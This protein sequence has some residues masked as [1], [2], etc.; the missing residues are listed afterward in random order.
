MLISGETSWNF[1]FVGF[2]PWQSNCW[3]QEDDG[4]LQRCCQN[5]SRLQ[6]LHL[7]FTHILNSETSWCHGKTSS[8]SIIKRP[9]HLPDT[10]HSISLAWNHLALCQC[11]HPSKRQTSP[12]ATSTHQVTDP[13]SSKGRST[14]SDIIYQNLL[15]G[16]PRARKNSSHLVFPSC[17]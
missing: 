2:E 11:L 8:S 3:D 4:N 13:G 1:L 9:H 10:F 6:W 15:Q 7:H 12:T 16:Q 14:H 17:N 5:P